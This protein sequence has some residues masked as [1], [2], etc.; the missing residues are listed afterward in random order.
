MRVGAGEISLDHQLRHLG[1][2]GR[3]QAHRLH[4]VPDQSTDGGGGN[5]PAHFT[6]L[7]SFCVMPLRIVA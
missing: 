5:Q 3:W 2:V 4:A 1:G 7:R 6:V